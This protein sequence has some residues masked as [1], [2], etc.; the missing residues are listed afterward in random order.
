LEVDVAKAKRYE[1]NE[2]EL[3][4][5]KFKGQAQL[6][7]KSLL[8]RHPQTAQEI[9][10]DIASRLTTRQD[11][12]RVVAFYL[13]TWKK[14]GLI[15]VAEDEAPVTTGNS[16][17][18]PV[19]ADIV[20]DEVASRDVERELTELEEQ[21][22]REDKFDYVNTALSE[23]VIGVL[24]NVL[25]DPASP[26]VIADELNVLGRTVTA[27]Q[28]SDAIRRLLDKGRVVKVGDGRYALPTRE[29]VGL[30]SDAVL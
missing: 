7:V 27:K 4:E 5:Q 21:P 3:G 11:P 1:L 12:I 17:E 30:S 22:E 23:T 13:S 18:A 29:S 9:A 26:K 28:V 16:S 2:T 19:A 14:S 6:I 20:S 8:D 15:L 24:Y 25:E 10:D